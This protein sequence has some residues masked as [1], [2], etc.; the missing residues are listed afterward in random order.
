MAAE[1]AP[2]WTR[3][4]ERYYP[5]A[6]DPNCYLSIPWLIHDMAGI[7]F[8]ARC[9]M[10]SSTHFDPTKGE[11]AAIIEVEVEF[12]LGGKLLLLL[13]DEG[14]GWNLFKFRPLVTSNNIVNYLRNGVIPATLCDPNPL[15]LDRVA[16]GQW[17]IWD[18]RRETAKK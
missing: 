8:D 18:V 10:V 12:G 6:N 15:S 7:P 5:R 3:E 17:E 1:G 16:V 2:G 9:I 13:F 4:V 14:L 11:N